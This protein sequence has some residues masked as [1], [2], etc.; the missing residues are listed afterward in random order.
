MLVFA[1]TLQVSP[2]QSGMEGQVAWGKAYFPFCNSNSNWSSCL[3]LCF[4]P[5]FNE[6]S[7]SSSSAQFL[8][9]S[10]VLTG[11]SQCRLCVLFSSYFIYHL[12]N[13]INRQLGWFVKVLYEFCGCYFLLDHK[14]VNVGWLDFMLTPGSGEAPL[15]VGAA[16]TPWWWGL[17]LLF[18]D[19]NFCLPPSCVLTILFLVLV[20]GTEMQHFEL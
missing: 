4:S 19:G 11:E 7:L 3:V 10:S 6:C 14:L 5:N 1:L 8:H 9:C 18:V 12:R 2:R 13:V 17:F 20:S 15:R 16:V